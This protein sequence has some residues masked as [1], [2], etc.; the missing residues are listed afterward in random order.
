MG[1]FC[2][3]GGGDVTPGHGTHWT[4]AP[5]THVKTS[6]SLFRDPHYKLL[7]KGNLFSEA[8]LSSIVYLAGNRKVKFLCNLPPHTL[9]SPCFSTFIYYKPMSCSEK[10]KCHSSQLIVF[11]AL[12]FLIRVCSFGSPARAVFFPSIKVQG[13]YPYFIF[14]LVYQTHGGLL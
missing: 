12:F 1:L 4:N 13:P 14:L 10:K 2:F 9:P 6:L 7:K 8:R 11:Q 3:W 5:L